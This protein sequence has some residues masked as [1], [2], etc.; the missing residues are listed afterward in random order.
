M[1]FLLLLKIQ[2]KII[3]DVTVETL[4]FSHHQK[5]KYDGREIISFFSCTTGACLSKTNQTRRRLSFFETNHFLWTLIQLAAQRVAV[6][7]A[8]VFV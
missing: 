8:Q 6:P 4:D 3:N 7:P 2:K 5:F 1:F